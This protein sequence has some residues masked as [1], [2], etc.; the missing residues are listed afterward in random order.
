MEIGSIESAGVGGS[1][2]SANVKLQNA[3]ADQQE[4]VVGKIMEGVEQAPA[5][6]ADGQ[7]GQ[8]LNVIA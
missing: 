5:P 2:S 3:A 7:T 8:G 1:V 6:R 4:A